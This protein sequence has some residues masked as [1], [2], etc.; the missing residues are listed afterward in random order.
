MG[1]PFVLYRAGGPRF[2]RCGKALFC[3]C[4][5]RFEGKH[6]G[7]VIDVRLV[8]ALSVKP[9]AEIVKSPG[10]VPVCVLFYAPSMASHALKSK[11]GRVIIVF[12]TPAT[13]PL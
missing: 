11:R 3:I 2:K 13:L 5:V 4:I 8:L 12:V 6:G 10:I 1:T 9:V 7:V